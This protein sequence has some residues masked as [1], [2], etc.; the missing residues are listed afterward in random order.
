MAG[1]P[2]DPAPVEAHGDRQVIGELDLQVVAAAEAQLRR[3]EHP[4]RRLRA[5]RDAGSGRPGA[6]GWPPAGAPAPGCR[7]AA[8]GRANAAPNP[9][10]SVRACSSRKSR[11]AMRPIRTIFEVDCPVAALWPKAAGMGHFFAA[12]GGLMIS[13][14]PR[15]ATGSASRK[16]DYS[17]V[18]SMTAA[19]KPLH[20]FRRHAPHRGRTNDAIQAGVAELVDALDLGSSDE[21]C[22][23]SSP[24]ARTK[25]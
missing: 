20:T 1:N 22:G 11:L 5:S 17:L 4:H 8:A 9:A 25:R 3:R 21:S 13:P 14:R 23:G 19:R 2:V 7:R 10:P 16:P 24:S 15:F 12:K 18:W 6:P